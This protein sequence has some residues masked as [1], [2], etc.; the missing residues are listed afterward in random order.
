MVHLRSA[1][2][3][4]SCRREASAITFDSEVD[5]I[6]YE[7]IE[8]SVAINVNERCARGPVGV[9]D[10][11]LDRDVT[12]CAVSVVVIE[13]VRSEVGDVDIEKAVVVVVA[14]GDAHWKADLADAGLLRHVYKPQ[15]PG[16]GQ[17]VLEEAIT[18]LPSRRRRK[19][20]LAR[21]IEL[22][23]LGQEDVEIAI[24]I[25]VEQSNARAHDLGHVVMCLWHR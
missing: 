14:D 13:H 6:A 16:F 7:E 22:R 18:G 12:E 23:A 19:E 8:P 2:V 1:V 24:T 17:Q 9:F 3:G 15:F 11:G 21:T 20:G 10:T 4:L 5:V 25:E